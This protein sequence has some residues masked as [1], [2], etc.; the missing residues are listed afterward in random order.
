MSRLV[1]KKGVDPALV[2]KAARAEGAHLNGVEA[3]PFFGIAVLA[4]NYA[5]IDNYTLNV[6]CGFYLVTRMLFNY[7]YI[8]N[9]TGTTA[10]IRSL[11]W[12]LSLGTP[13][14][15]LGKATSLLANK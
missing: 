9:T 5:G 4:G 11:V 1:E 8:N 2:A 10:N 7:I 3:L 12:I 13:F 6:A 14:Y 15:L